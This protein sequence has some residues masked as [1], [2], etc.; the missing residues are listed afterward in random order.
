MQVSA[1]FGVNYPNADRSDSADVPRDFLSM[2]TGLE[3][4][5]RYGQGTLAARPVSTAGTPGIQG[6]VY[7]VTDQ[8]PHV[9]YYDFGTGWDLV[10][11]PTSGVGLLAARPSAASLIAGT[12]YYATDQDAMY[13]VS[14]GVWIRVGSMP[15]DLVMTLNA[16]ASTGRVLCQGQN[17]SRVGL[18]ADLFAKWGTAYGV[19]DGSTTFTLPDMRGRMPVA[20]GT[21]ADIAAIGAT[22]GLA[23]VGARRPRHKHTVGIP[24]GAQ[25]GKTFS[26]ASAGTATQPNEPG[27]VPTVGPQT[28]FEP[29]DS[30]AYFVV[31]FEA[32]L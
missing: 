28:G 24:A 23:N 16:V 8:T 5:V 18:F 11:A 27:G 10:G 15:G 14:A 30:A 9:L 1:R 26:G 3:K 29:V 31:N 13:M 32:K 25:F 2:V 21:H 4:A 19:G 7:M 12:T 17:I 6:R 20:L 22:D